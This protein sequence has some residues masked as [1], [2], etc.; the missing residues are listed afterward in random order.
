ML[1]DEGYRPADFQQQI[2]R[3]WRK[4]VMPEDT[5]F[6]LGDVIL[7]RPSELAVINASLPGKKILIRGNHDRESDGWYERAGFAFVAQAVLVGGVY[8]THAPQVTLPDGAV[9]NVHGHLHAG[10]HRPGNY[11]PHCKLLALEH[12]GY[13]PIEMQEF[14]GFSP[15]RRKILMPYDEAT[16]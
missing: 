4:I 6:H 14:V 3:N 7:S 9:I 12:D 13:A 1:V 15:M 10:T 8:L 11:A 16:P 5:V 2:I